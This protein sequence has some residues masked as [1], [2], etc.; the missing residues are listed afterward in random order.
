MMSRKTHRSDV[1]SWL[2][3]VICLTVATSA[4]AGTGH[5]VSGP[6]PQPTTACVELQAVLAGRVS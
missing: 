5:V 2:K 3:V 6:A 4:A 1:P